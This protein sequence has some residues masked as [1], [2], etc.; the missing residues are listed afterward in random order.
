MSL[1]TRVVRKNNTAPQNQQISTHSFSRSPEP[2]HSS[3][4]L[5]LEQFTRTRESTIKE[6]IVYRTDIGWCYLL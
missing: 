5:V 3:P 4:G 2:K 1:C 6:G